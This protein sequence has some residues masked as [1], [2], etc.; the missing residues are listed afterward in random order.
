MS[1]LLLE[2]AVPRGF[3]LVVCLVYRLI[4]I[5]IAAIGAWF[6][7]SVKREVIHEIEDASQ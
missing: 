4:T 2:V 7:I 5:G 6:Y 3:G 1:F